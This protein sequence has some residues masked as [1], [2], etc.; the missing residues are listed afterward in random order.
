MTAS[1]DNDVAAITA[2]LADE[3]V[4]TILLETITEPMS[5][6]TLSE[7]C[8]VSPQTVYRR[9]DDLE[10]HDLVTE[11]TRLDSAGHHHKVYAATLDRLVV[12]LTVDGFE[13]QLTRRER[14]ADRFTQFIEDMR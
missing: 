7:R 2:L 9:L 8:D 3:C 12:D 11:Q 5:A 13:L 1:D 4:R 6:E 10:E 14:M